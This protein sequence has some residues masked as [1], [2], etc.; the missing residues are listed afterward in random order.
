MEQKIILANS[1]HALNDKIKESI[2][3]KWVPVGSHCIITV[4]KQNSFRGDILV[5][6]SYTNEYSQT[7]KREP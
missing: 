1:V 5:N 2:L 3:N 7:I 4:H 6:S